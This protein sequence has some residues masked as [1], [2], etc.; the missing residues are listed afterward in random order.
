MS[1][2]CAAAFCWAFFDVRL[3]KSEG[4]TAEGMLDL[5][6][7]AE[8]CRGWVV[9]GEEGVVEVVCDTFPFFFDGLDRRRLA[10]GW[11]VAGAL[12]LLSA[13]GLVRE[14]GTSK[15]SPFSIPSGGVME[16]AEESEDVLDAEFARVLRR[17]GVAVFALPLPLPFTPLVG[18]LDGAILEGVILGDGSGSLD[19]RRLFLT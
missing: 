3:G 13:A 16:R 2:A 9:V 7:A 12:L 6:A 1:R 10:I 17:D 15:T 8:E 14:G 19:E 18:F 5:E 4:P 11:E